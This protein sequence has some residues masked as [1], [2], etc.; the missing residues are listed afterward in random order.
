MA[1]P[2]SHIWS[3]RPL[4]DVVFQDAIKDNPYSPN[5]F[6]IGLSAKVCIHLHQLY[7]RRLNNRIP[8]RQ[9][10]DK[11]TREDRNTRH[12]TDG[13]KLKEGKANFGHSHEIKIYFTSSE[14]IVVDDDY[15]FSKDDRIIEYHAHLKFWIQ[16]KIFLLTKFMMRISSLYHLV[17]VYH[18]RQL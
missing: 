18:M 5:K 7:L 16:L 12:K 11:M 9:I 6:H 17:I 3:C 14:D 2:I 1:V 15:K 4:P 8:P 10:A 13:D